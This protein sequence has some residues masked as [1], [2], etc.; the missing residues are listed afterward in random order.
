MNT[1]RI[2][3]A[4]YGNNNYYDI[5]FNLFVLWRNNNS[6][7][8]CIPDNDIERLQYSNYQDPDPNI[9]KIILLNYIEDNNEFQKIVKSN[10]KIYITFDTISYRDILL[11]DNILDPMIRLQKLH[12][13][14]YI[15]SWDVLEVPEQIFIMKYLD[16]KDI[17]LE[18]GSNIGRSTVVAASILEDDR[19]LVTLECDPVSYNLLEQN[20]KK[21]GFN[22]KTINAALSKYHL[23]Q[24]GWKTFPTNDIENSVNIID[25]D[26]IKKYF[27]KPFNVLIVDCENAF[28]NILKEFPEVMENITKVIIENDFFSVENL[29]YV[30][31]IL[32]SHGLKCVDRKELEPVHH[33]SH[34][35]EVIPRFYEVWIK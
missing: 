14:I 24:E 29:N 23:S 6:E 33:V 12:N 13:N 31:N 11:Y 16:K 21:Y 3:S 26:S 27:S 18:F 32:E 2:R 15:D 5:T 34:I 25:L 8:I 9:E 28:T 30:T 1:Y 35:P 19:N 20:R 10:E 22:F 7:P 4:Y 17:V